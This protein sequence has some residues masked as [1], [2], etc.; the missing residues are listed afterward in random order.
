MQRTTK[1]IVAFSIIPQV[2][3]IKLLSLK[4]EWIETFYSNGIYPWISKAMHFS[5]GWI[6]VSIGDLLYTLASIYVIR[7]LYKNRKHFIKDFKTYCID[8]LATISIAFF[9][10]HMLWALNYNRLPLHHTLE[11][12]NSYTTE[13]LKDTT[14]QLIEKVNSLHDSLSVS[15]TL[16]VEFP[17]SKSELLAQIPNGYSNLSKQYPH[18][19]YSHASIKPSLYSLQ[20]TYMGFSGYLNPFTNEAQI[21]DM[22]PKYKYPTTG[23][24][25]VAHQLG[26]AAENEANFIGFMAATHNDN[27]YFKYSGYAFALK[28]CLAEI[29]LRDPDY[30]KEIKTTLNKGVFKNYAEVR[31]FWDSYQN[32]IEPLFKTTYNSYL[33]ANNQAGGIESYSYVVALLVNYFEKRPSHLI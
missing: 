3:I 7:W 4:P 2:I 11:V 18:L 10:F 24:H 21:D 9:A 23:S 33:E 8:V 27:I 31:N 6:P 12:D 20:L 25:E 30:F 19:S 15:D 32:P 1:K 5:F 29:Y 28:H 16:K 26:Y 13:E 14:R 17:Y 22:I